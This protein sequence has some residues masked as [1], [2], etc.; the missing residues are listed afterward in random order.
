MASPLCVAVHLTE[1]EG[2]FECDTFFPPL[3]PAVFRLWHALPP[4]F[5]GGVRYT[6]ACYVRCDGGTDIPAPCLP[7]ASTANGLAEAPREKGTVP[8]KDTPDAAALALPV[9]VRRRHEEYQYLDLV[10]N[11]ICTG[12]AKGDRT[13]T[14][15]LSKFG[16]QVLRR[17]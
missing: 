5:D 3:D 11:I 6:I 12:A 14:G 15:T 9:A 13:G 17:C 16:C 8:T 10:S 1:V 4:A 7:K 2:D